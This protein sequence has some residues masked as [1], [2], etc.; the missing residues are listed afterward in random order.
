MDFADRVKFIRR[1]LGLTQD[2][3]AQKLGVDRTSIVAW[4][5]RRYL[6][7]GANLE[8][9]A[10]ALETT[11]A[12]L[13]CGANASSV[14]TDDA[15]EQ[16]KKELMRRQTW[17]AYKIIVK[18]AKMLES[19]RNNYKY[20]QEREILI[21]SSQLED[22]K[23]MING[24][25]EARP[26]I[27]LYLL[28]E[29]DDNACYAN[30]PEL[31]DIPGPWDIVRDTDERAKERR[32]AGRYADPEMGIFEIIIDMGRIP[33]ATRRGYKLYKEHEVIVLSVLLDAYIDL[34]NKIRELQPWKEPNGNDEE[35][36]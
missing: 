5:N 34:V 15:K 24:I 1:K 4:E 18:I 21:L 11:V 35:K 2:E 7:E 26:W 22:Y 31:D 3:L 33:D 16:H 27:G 8:K 30:D 14:K 29:A 12:Y 10:N 32:I 36:H 9:L 20:Y 23:K 6:P 13:L 17:G 25:R 19:S 28:V